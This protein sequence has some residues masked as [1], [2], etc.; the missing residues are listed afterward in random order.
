MN[1][2]KDQEMGKDVQKDCDGNEFASRKCRVKR[3]NRNFCDWGGFD[4][5]ESL[6]GAGSC[7]QIHCTR[8]LSIRF[9]G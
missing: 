2:A 7:K 6:L 1:L 8:W 3:Y 5:C 9:G 4:E